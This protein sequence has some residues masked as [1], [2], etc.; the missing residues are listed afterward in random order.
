M[1]KDVIYFLPSYSY[2]LK[3]LDIWPF[4]PSPQDWKAAAWYSPNS[5]IRPKPHS[6]P[7]P[8]FHTLG[9]LTLQFSQHNSLLHKAPRWNVQLLV[10]HL[11]LLQCW[12]QNQDTTCSEL[13]N[14][15]RVKEYSCIVGSKKKKAGLDV[16]SNINTFNVSSFI[17]LETLSK[18]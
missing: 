15:R 5:S 4:S 14:A 8:T 1:F 18:N 6:F 10:Q 12:K 11:L 17:S 13:C 2:I 3:S 16:D 7:S 9:C